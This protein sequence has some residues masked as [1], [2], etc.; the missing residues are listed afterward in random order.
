MTRTVNVAAVVDNATPVILL[1]GGAVIDLTV[2]GTYTELGADCEDDA[3]GDKDATVSG[4][5]V[6]T[7]TAGEY[8]VRYN[9]TD[10][11][12][13]VADEVTRTVNVA[14][15][16]DNATPVI[17][18]RG[19]AVIDLTVGGTYTELG[20]DCEDDADGDKDATVSGHTVN[21]STAGEYIVRYNCTDSDGN[22]A[23][24]VTRTV[25]V[26]A[27]V[28]NAIPVISLEGDPVIDLTVG[29]TYTE[30]GAICKDDVD[31]DKA[32]T[33][34][35]PTVDTS[36]VGEYIVTYNCDRFRWKYCRRGD[37]NSKRSS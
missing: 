4:H 13:N 3:D 23:D 35:G 6:N 21:T 33:V 37:Q 28:D 18:L 9:C 8:I 17:L 15:V 19:G 29:D 24:E 31:N 26:A 30:Q 10:S 5:T 2:G 20:A 7:S 36:T 14:A 22:V 16:V 27:V 11:D 1:R 25:N 34:G 12:G 32:A